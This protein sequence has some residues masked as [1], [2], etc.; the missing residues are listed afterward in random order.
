MAD[1]FKLIGELHVKEEKGT[2]VVTIASMVFWLSQ[3][4]TNLTK[5]PTKITWQANVTFPPCPRTWVGVVACCMCWALKIA[6]TLV[7]QNFGWPSKC[8]ND[9]PPPRKRTPS[10]DVFFRLNMEIVQCHVSFQGCNMFRGEP[11]NSLVGSTF[12]DP[13]TF[14]GVLSREFWGFVVNLPLTTLFKDLGLFH[15]EVAEQK[16]T[17]ATGIH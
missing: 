15:F 8:Q 4:T 14:K 10:E 7:S 2:W 6:M 9:T 5:V 12:V 1:G 13:L 3:V 11:K 17:L 16:H